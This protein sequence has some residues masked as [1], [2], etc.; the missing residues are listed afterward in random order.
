[1]ITR[2]AP[3][4]VALFS[5]SGDILQLEGQAQRHGVSG[6]NCLRALEDTNAM[7]KRLP[8]EQLHDNTI[9]KNT[10]LKDV[11]SK[12]WCRLGDSNT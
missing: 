1:M 10:I 12:N 5:R 7:L 4:A 9:L 6:A 3:G 11:A 8:A 2:L